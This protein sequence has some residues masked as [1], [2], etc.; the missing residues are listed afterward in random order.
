MTARLF[1]SWGGVTLLD[2]GLENL[3]LISLFTRKGWCGNN[4]LD[5][6][7]GSGFLEACDQPI[8]ASALNEI[9]DAA[10][11]AMDDSLFGTV[12][13]TVTNPT[14]SYL[15]VTLLCQRLGAQIELTRDGGG[16]SAQ[17]LNPAYLEISD[18]V[19]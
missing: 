3:A 4:F 7:I 19:S 14:G 13:A 15:S 1:R 6:E 8:T 16:W 5:T 2:A 18:Y 10:E 9:R 17:T 12:T 11:K